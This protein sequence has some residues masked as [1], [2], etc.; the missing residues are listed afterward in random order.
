M[1]FVA[2]GLFGASWPINW[3]LH[4]MYCVLSLLCFFSHWVLPR[5]LRFVFDGVWPSYNKGLLTYLRAEFQ[6]RE[7][8]SDIS[9]LDLN[10][11]CCVSEPATVDGVRSNKSISTFCWF[12][13]KLRLRRGTSTASNVS[14]RSWEQ[15]SRSMWD[16]NAEVMLRASIIVSQADSAWRVV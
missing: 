11:S 14:P 4:F 7:P 9:Q 13:A 1:L 10:A 12:I 15:Y 3:C 16:N 5:M 8:T 6:A 2:Y